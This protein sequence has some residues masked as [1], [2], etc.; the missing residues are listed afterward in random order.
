LFSKN[1]MYFSR[2][3]GGFSMK[4]DHAS[5]RNRLISIVRFFSCTTFVILL[6]LQFGCSGDEKFSNPLVTKYHY[7]HVIDVHNH[8]ASGYRYMSSVKTWDN[9][10]IEQIVLFG[11]ISEPSAIETDNIAWD[12]YKNDDS[13]YFP[14]FA[15]FDIHDRNCLDVV[16]ER[17]ELGY[18][19][20]GEFVAAST[21]SPITA[22]LPWKGDHPMDGYFPQVYQLCA[23]YKSPILLHIDPPTGFPIDK[24]EEAL[25]SFPQTIFIFGH[26]NAYN[27]PSNLEDLLA[28]YNN[29]Y[30]DFFAG[31]TRYNPGSMNSLNDFVPV[32]VKYPHR[33]LIST[34][35]GFDVGYDSAYT[36]IYELFE[37]LDSSTIE[38]IAHK[39]I[40]SIFESEPVTE[41]QWQRIY[42]IHDQHPDVIMDTAGLNRIRANRWIFR[43]E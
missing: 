31:F 21:N 24:L 26:A 13:R 10:S 27:A 36:A 11:D 40:E 37:L 41:S 25:D 38:L 29:I 18:F 20:I 34:D 12:A 30:I 17:F 39:N 33:F 35:S 8:D 15:G 32:I 43:N 19:G 3:N 23:D 4:S 16:K 6:L 1:A 2:K 28:H 7:V 14:F 9:Y 42:S 22:N 5:I